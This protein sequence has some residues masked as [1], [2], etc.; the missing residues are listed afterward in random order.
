VI[1]A[2][3]LLAGLFATA[4]ALALLL[5][6]FFRLA[7]RVH[8]RVENKWA[9][10]LL[11]ILLGVS[12]LLVCLFLGVIAPIL[13]ARFYGGVTTLEGLQAYVGASSIIGLC[14]IFYTARTPAGQQYAKAGIWGPK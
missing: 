2:L 14:V 7:N 8:A 11:V 13:L 4:V 1:S 12:V 6:G 9:G 5:G 10:R 3:I